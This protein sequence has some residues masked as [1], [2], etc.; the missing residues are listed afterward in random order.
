MS[1]YKNL[2]TKHFAEQLEADPDA[3]LLDVRSPGEFAEAHIPGAR[4]LN[5]MSPD[6][7]R[8]VKQLPKDKAY[9]LYCRSGGR[10]ASAC[11]FMASQ[12]FTELYNLDQGIL[13]WD[14]PTERGL[15]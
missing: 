14:G 11:G 4:L 9:Y 13:D 15:N 5:I 8:T 12:G 6:F 3:E 7:V 10:S 1:A 2:S